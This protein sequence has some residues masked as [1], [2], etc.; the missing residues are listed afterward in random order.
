MLVQVKLKSIRNII[1]HDLGR[2]EEL[3]RVEEKLER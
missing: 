3:M 1:T 2:N